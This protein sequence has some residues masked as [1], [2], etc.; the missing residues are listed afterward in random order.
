[1]LLEA[2]VEQKSGTLTNQLFEYIREKHPRSWPGISEAFE[3]DPRRFVELVDMFLGWLTE[4]RGVPGMLAATDSFVQFTSDV[5]LAQ[6]RYERAGK[7]AEL[8]FDDV[9]ASHYSDDEAMD[10]YLWGLFLANFL[11]QHHFSLSLFFQDRFLARLKPDTELLELAPGHGGWGAWALTELAESRLRGYDISPQSIRVAREITSAAGLS[12]RAEYVEGDALAVGTN[13]PESAD[14]AIS[15][16][17]AEH[18]PDPGR[19]FAA[20]HG[21]L[22]P[23]GLAFVTVALTA[24]QVDH[25]YE[26]RRESEVVTMCEDHGFRV[27]EM[28]SAG[29]HRTLPKAQFL[30]RSVAV[31]LQKRTNNIF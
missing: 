5:N 13:S 4:S 17:L 6:A 8:S 14:A 18:L 3:T 1:M 10:Y 27:L 24:A 28:L 25:V 26:F 23:R 21:A 30:P 11:W 7:Y 19:L 29:P 22:R 16:C 2:T 31:V 15:C 20:I 9:Y 12:E